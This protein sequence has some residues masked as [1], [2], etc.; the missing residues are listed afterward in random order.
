MKKRA[1]REEKWTIFGSEIVN[2]LSANAFFG[3]KNIFV[4]LQDWF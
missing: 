3:Q 2:F 1:N 4:S